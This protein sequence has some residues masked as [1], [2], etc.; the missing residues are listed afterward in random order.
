VLS[1]KNNNL[2]AAGGKA[3]AEGLKGN[4]V[5]T[6]LNI[7]GTDLVWYGD[8]SGG[9]ALADAIPSM[10][11]LTKLIFGGDGYYNDTGH[12]VTPEPATLE[13]GMTKADFSNKHLGA[14]G[15]IIISAW[16]SHKDNGVLAS[17]NL[18]SNTIGGYYPDRSFTFITTPEG[19]I[20]ALS[21]LYIP[22]APFLM[23]RC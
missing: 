20:A 23:Y 3:L 2:R 11:A 1:L 14:A 9:T 8:M 19:I 22:H 16:I 15:A 17:L 4:Q 6:E 12:K 18:A 13:V 7:A 5:I 21:P 10:G